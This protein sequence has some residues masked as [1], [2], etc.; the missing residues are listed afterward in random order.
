VLV[1]KHKLLKAFRLF[2]INQFIFC[3]LFAFSLSTFLHFSRSSHET[4]PLSPKNEFHLKFEKKINGYQ[5]VEAL[6]YIVFRFG[7]YCWRRIRKNGTVW[8]HLSHKKVPLSLTRESTWHSGI[9]VF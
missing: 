2:E 7:C 8:K 6:H 4:R 3:V 1:Y 5:I 9:R